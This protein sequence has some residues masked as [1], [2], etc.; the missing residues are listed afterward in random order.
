MCWF[1]I[2]HARIRLGFTIPLALT[3]RLYLQCIHVAG[4]AIVV[5]IHLVPSWSAQHWGLRTS[6]QL[7]C[8]THH[9]SSFLTL[10]LPSNGA[11]ALLIHHE[12]F[13]SPPP[14]API[15]LHSSRARKT[16]IKAGLSST[17]YRDTLTVS[18][19]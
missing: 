1:W 3:G 2:L 9:H 15:N 4:R 10:K 13:N 17:H 16:K 8:Q 12:H 11:S 18:P 5:F 19:C 7:S 14:P 6:I